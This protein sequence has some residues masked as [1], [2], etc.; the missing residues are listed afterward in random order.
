MKLINNPVFSDLIF[1]GVMLI[2]SVLPELT[3]TLKLRGFLVR[4][5]F[6]S[7]GKNLQLTKDVRI[8]Q[9]KNIDIGNDVFLSAGVWVLAS[10]K[11]VFGDG[12]MMGPYSI[13]I[14]GDH[15]RY[16]GSFRFGKAVRA[17]ITLGCGSWIGA[18]SVVAK[19]VT[20]GNGAVLA[21]CSVATKNVP[22]MAVF[23]GVPAKLIRQD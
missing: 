9:C 22:E 18:H 13:I 23:G 3:P 11:V 19:G 10:N 17:P 7:C 20:I 6:N 2:T 4:K 16:N 1:R 12:V 21:A 14:T 8:N 15:T 5:C